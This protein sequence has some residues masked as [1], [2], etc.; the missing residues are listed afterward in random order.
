MRDTENRNSPKCKTLSFKHNHHHLFAQN[1]ST[2]T[3]RRTVHTK[4]Q[5]KFNCEISISVSNYIVSKSKLF[6]IEIVISTHP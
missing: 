3:N 2:I 5:S 1:N 4:K 6:E